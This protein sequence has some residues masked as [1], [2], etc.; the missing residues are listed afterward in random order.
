MD[1]FGEIVVFENRRKTMSVIK[2]GYVIYSYVNLTL[3]RKPIGSG[4][5]S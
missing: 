1:E 3:R 5:R 4:T 2:G